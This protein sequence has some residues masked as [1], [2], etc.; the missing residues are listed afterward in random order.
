MA[1]LLVQGKRRVRSGAAGA[2]DASYNLEVIT[3]MRSLET[4]GKRFVWAWAIVALG[5]AGLVAGCGGGGGGSKAPPDT[6][7]PTVV[8]TSYTR[9]LAATGGT[10][11]IEATATDAGGVGKVEARVTAPDGQVSLVAMS[12]KGAN[13]YSG[14]YTAA[15][16]AGTTSMVYKFTVLANDNAG[17][18]GSDGEYTFEV[19]SA[20]APPAPPP[21]SIK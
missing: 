16:N 14:P 7:A 13:V 21:F 1:R 8:V 5:T 3:Y 15:A 19:P 12:P 20:E 2:I 9:F 18:T 6:T 4:R 17:N 10:A 11:V